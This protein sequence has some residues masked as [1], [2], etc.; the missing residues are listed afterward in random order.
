MQTCVLLEFFVRF[1][2]A[3]TPNG[4]Y[5]VLCLTGLIAYGIVLAA[6]VKNSHAFTHT[7]YVLVWYLAVADI[8]YLMTDLILVVP[9]SFANAL[10]F[11]KYWTD[12][13]ANLDTLFW[14]MICLLMGTFY[15]H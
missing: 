9:A 15:W 5:L 11:G 6:I 4:I 1:V 3:I 13:I 10:P 2:R 7:F 8:A 14:F 12:L